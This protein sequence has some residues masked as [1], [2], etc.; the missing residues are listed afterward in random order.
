MFKLIKKKNK[1]IIIYIKVRMRQMVFPGSLYGKSEARY[2]N[3]VEMKC[4]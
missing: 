3:Y 4:K 2:E 1:N